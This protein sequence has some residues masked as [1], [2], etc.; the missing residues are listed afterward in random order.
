[1]RGICVRGENLP[2]IVVCCKDVCVE[3]YIHRCSTDF[4]DYL[5]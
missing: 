4:Y 5:P 1:M 3:G 2:Q